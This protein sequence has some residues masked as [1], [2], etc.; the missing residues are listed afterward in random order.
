MPL[1]NKMNK[2]NK[3]SAERCSELLVKAMELVA[4]K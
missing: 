4:R 2:I 1:K 3:S